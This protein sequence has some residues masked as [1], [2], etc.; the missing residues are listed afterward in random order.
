MTDFTEKVE[1]IENLWLYS[2]K[3]GK[4]GQRFQIL[5][6]FGFKDRDRYKEIFN[7]RSFLC[8]IKRHQKPS[9]IL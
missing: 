7:H 9:V 6:T 1:R 5:T 2:P 8:T 3:H 4:I